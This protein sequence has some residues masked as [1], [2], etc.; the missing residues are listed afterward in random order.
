[1]DDIET[2]QKDTA[3]SAPTPPQTT[4]EKWFYRLKFAT[5]EGV[6]LFLT[7]I[8]AYAARYVD[9]FGPIPNYLKKFQDGIYSVLA[10]N[11]RYPVNERLAGTIAGTTI[12]MHG[13]NLFTPVMKWMEDRKESIVT[14]INK[15]WGK[16]GEVEAGHERL[17]DEPKQ[18]WGD[19]IKGRL[20]AWLT[21][22]STFVGIDAIIG[23][24]KNTLGT[25]DKPIYYF[26]KFEEMFGRWVARIRTPVGQALT[27]AETKSRTYRFGKIL[28]LDI[29]AT[30]ASLLVW[31]IVSKFSAALRGKKHPSAPVEN[32]DPTV[33]IAQAIA[34]G[35][36]DI[37]I[38]DKESKKDS[39]A[40]NKT[41]D[42]L[43]KGT[44]D[45]RTRQMDKS[46][47]APA[48]A[49]L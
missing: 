43:T 18:N 45:F 28:A 2:T 34:T 29:Y 44:A 35:K 40:S 11:K 1:M 36:E 24:D 19:V 49:A 3:N 38:A 8:I 15:R 13:G 20:V 6:I 12:L 22:F 21:V 32:D 48:A 39:P 37:S 5:G 31:T 46:T 10:N 4:G 42:I 33:N 17:K 41:K 16:P 25:N 27:E 23:K 26:D 9:H 14:Y 7:A 47:A 30:A